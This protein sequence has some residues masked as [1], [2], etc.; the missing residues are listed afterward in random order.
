HAPPPAPAPPPKLDTNAAVPAPVPNENIQPPEGPPPSTDPS[1]H[2]QQLQLHYPPVGMGYVAGSSPQAMDD[3]RTEKVP[4][5][6]IKVP[7]VQSPTPA[8]P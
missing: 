6:V 2:P 1:F 7:L 5:V 3:Y 8:P 4:G